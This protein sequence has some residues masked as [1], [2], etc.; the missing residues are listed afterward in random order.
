VISTVVVTGC[1]KGIG[2]ATALKLAQESCKVYAVSRNAA[3]LQTLAQ[4]SQNIQPITADISTATGREHIADSLKHETSFSLI[5]NAGV[6]QPSPFQELQESVLRQHFEINFFAPLLLTQRLLAQLKGQR[7][8]NISS[9]AVSL[10]L[11]SKLAYCTSKS[12]MHHAMQCLN[13]EFAAQ[14]IL[15]GNLRPG[16]V[17]TDM[18]K[19][20]R[21]ADAATLPSKNFYLQ[22]HTE[23]KLI[24]P[25]IAAAFI[26]WV[27]LNSE[28]QAFA[29]TFWNIYDEVH[30]AKWLTPGAKIPR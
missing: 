11:V 28:D 26:A 25:E 1:S 21:N 23:G 8:L 2:Y 15:F 20:L 22:A 10:A 27:L 5:H 12:A 17:D 18:Q 3:A 24:A 13:A 29:E 9:G 7:V 14:G 30:Q 4:Q 16:M 19:A 6:S